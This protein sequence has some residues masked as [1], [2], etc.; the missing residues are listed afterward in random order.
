MKPTVFPS[1]TPT[2]GPTKSATEFPTFSP[3]TCVDDPDWMTGGTHP[4]YSGIKCANIGSDTVWCEALKGKAYE[5]MSKTI[6]QACCT[7]GGSKFH[8][9]F[10]SSSP[11]MNPSDEPST[12][13]TASPSLHPTS[14]PTTPPPTGRPTMSPT[15]CI[16]EPG[17]TFNKG[18]TVYEACC[19]CGGGKHVVPP[20]TSSPTE[21]PTSSPTASPTKI[22]TMSPS[23]GPSNSPITPPPTGRPTMSPTVCIDEPGWTFSTNLGCAQIDADPPLFCKSVGDSGVVNKGKTVYE[24]CCSCGGGKHVVPPPTSSPTVSPTAIPT[25]APS[26]SIEPSSQPSGTP[27]VSPTTTPSS[28]PSPSPTRNPSKTPSWKPSPSPTECIDDHEW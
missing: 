1:S 24:A 2:Y 10:P 26:F 12:L 15:V 18:K 6:D 5:Y 11:S 8:T 19:S 27:T 3:T 16:D 23:K 7:C 22:P 20:P 25:I 14:Q 28:I 13:P 4:L 21:I 9:T 17:W